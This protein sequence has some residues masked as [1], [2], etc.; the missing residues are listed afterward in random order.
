AA[1]GPQVPAA[2]RE[3]LAIGGRLVMPV[4]D[5]PREQRLVRVRRTREEEYEEEDLLPVRFVPLI[6]EQGWE[7]E[8]PCA[9][10][11][12][13]APTRLPQ[14]IAQAAGPFRSLAGARL[15]PLLERIG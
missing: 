8:A 9:R 7:E 14:R 10:R 3:Q 5:T 6:G 11:V 1:G 13:R 2:L 15:E 4:G 12:A